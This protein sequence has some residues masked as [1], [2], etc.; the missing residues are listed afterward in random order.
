MPSGSRVPELGRGCG[1]H[2]EAGQDGGSIRNTMFQRGG[3]AAEDSMRRNKARMEFVAVTATLNQDMSCLAETPTPEGEEGEACGILSSPIVPE[4]EWWRHVLFTTR[5]FS[6]ITQV[7]TTLDCGFNESFRQ[8]LLEI[9]K[10][11]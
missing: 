2:R 4:W 1:G 7:G 10:L 5:T 9:H 3:E 8:D 6:P 11:D